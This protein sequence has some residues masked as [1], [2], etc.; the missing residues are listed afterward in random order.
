MSLADFKN[1]MR[2][3][4]AKAAAAVAIAGH[5]NTAE[6]KELPVR[7]KEITSEEQTIP[8]KDTLKTAQ[9]EKTLNL[10]GVAELG[11]YEQDGIVYPTIDGKPVLSNVDSSLRK[12]LRR[13]KAE[14]RKAFRNAEPDIVDTVRVEQFWD[15]SDAASFQ[16]QGKNMR[17][18]YFETT[19]DIEKLRQLIRK[20]NPGLSEEFIEQKL[21]TQLSTTKAMN[22]KNSPEFLGVKAHEYQHKLD[23]RNNIYAPGLSAKQY[24]NLYQ[25]DELGG[26]VAN[27]L[28]INHFYNEKIKAGERPEEAAKLFDSALNKRFDFYKEAL[29]AGL[30]PDSDEAKKLM[31]LG[32]EKMWKKNYQSFYQEDI[33][34]FGTVPLYSNNA[35]TLAIGNEAE[36]QKR[37]AKIFDSFDDNEV[38]KDLGIK[39]GKLSK[40][41]SESELRLEPE[42]Q[43]DIEEESRKYTRLESEQAKRLAD[44][45]PGGPKKDARTLLK[46]LTGRKTLP[47][48]FAKP[49]KGNGQTSEILK[50]KAIRDKLRNSR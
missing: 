31:L 39:T 25:Y 47:K 46:I 7:D 45:I 40:Y 11:V 43:K 3:K 24:A 1:F 50:N 2:G 8:P 49:I 22:D 34:Q 5:M 23:D 12:E 30:N 15:I 29:Q 27:L 6:A 9:D 33:E 42:L 36:Y 41:L 19:D 38:L 14:Q 10:F 13:F 18:H 26:T 17:Y 20:K 28:V 21:Q 48:K 37:V 35:A 4:G 44:A 32:S 16:T